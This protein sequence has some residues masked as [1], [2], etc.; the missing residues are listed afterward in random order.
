MLETR[1]SGKGRQLVQVSGPMYGQLQDQ[2]NRP[3]LI[4]DLEHTLEEAIM[5]E[6]EI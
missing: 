6:I 3:K 4:T 2:M 5:P 1:E